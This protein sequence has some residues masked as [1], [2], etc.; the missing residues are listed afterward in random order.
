MS[1][2]TPSPIRAVTSFTSIDTA[3]ASAPWKAGAF[4]VSFG[5]FWGPY[6]CVPRLE[7]TQ[8]LSFW[9]LLFAFL[10]ATC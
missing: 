4:T 10:S 2:S 8:F 3:T 7:A 1:P 9:P 5:L 6:C